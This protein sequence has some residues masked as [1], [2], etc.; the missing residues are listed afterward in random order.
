MRK[1]LLPIVAAAGLA[2]ASSAFAATA[3]GTFN[4]QVTI[5][6]A[7]S[8]AATAVNFGNLSTILGTESANSTV[9]VVCNVGTPYNLSFIS[10][11]NAA[12]TA[13][14]NLVN[15]ANTIPVNYAFANAAAAAGTGTAT[16]TIAVSLPTATP[17]PA[18]GLYQQTQTVY[19]NY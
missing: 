16:N 12:I 19:V 17:F 11:N 2:S 1:Y 7:C 3:S 5:V 18:T 10:G 15:G 4:V 14:G 6:K 8:V 13:S 9:S